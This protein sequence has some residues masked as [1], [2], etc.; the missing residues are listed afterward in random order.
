LTSTARGRRQ[1]V[2]LAARSAHPIPALMTVPAGASAECPAPA[3]LLLHGY[4]S[5]KEHLA[6][7]LG[8]V[9]MK[10]GIAS[11]AIDLPLHGERRGDMDQQAM[12]NPLALAGAWRQGLSDSQTAFDYLRQRDDVA[13]DA[14]GI[15]GYSMGSFL[16][17]EIASRHASV[18]ALVLAAG[19]DLPAQTPF[20]RLV[21]TLA[22]PV[23]AV[24]RYAGRP[25]LMVH[26]RH[27]PIVTPAQAQRLFDAAK[28]PKSLQWW[29]AGHYLPEAAI[30][31]ACEWLR[32]RLDGCTVS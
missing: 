31:A 15:V 8:L 6:G 16:G 7:S 19:G 18:K 14:C 13:A 20:A 22:D 17:V 11:L 2:T 24:K 25:L 3:V 28:E 9:L 23:R 10:H 4:R 26:G 32:S 27:D 12:G 30:D 21:R 1:A 5:Q 29:D